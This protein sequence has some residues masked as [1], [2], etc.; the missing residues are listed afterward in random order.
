LRGRGGGAGRPFK[1][2]VLSSSASVPLSLEVLAHCDKF[3]GGRSLRSVNTDGVSA[4]F[5]LRPFR[6]YG[7]G[8]RDNS[9]RGSA[10]G[11]SKS[12]AFRPGISPSSSSL[13]L[14]AM[15]P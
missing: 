12:L 6:W 10:A 2:P 4:H 13:S 7:W 11:M 1:I 9:R 8:E 5:R 15:A 14:E 3:R